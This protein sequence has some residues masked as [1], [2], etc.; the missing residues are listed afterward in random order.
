MTTTGVTLNG[1]SYTLDLSKY[2][3]GLESALRQSFNSS[4]EPGDGA[5]ASNAV[6][7]RSQ[8]DFS[9]GSG[10]R[11]FDPTP[12]SNRSSFHESTGIDPWRKGYLSLLPAV[13]SHSTNLASNGELIQAGRYVVYAS[14]TSGTINVYDPSNG[15]TTG[16]A[17]G[18]GAIS[19]LAADGEVVYVA[20]ASKLR[21]FT[22]ATTTAADFVNSAHD[23][24]AVCHGRVIAGNG[25]ALYEYSAAGATLTTFTAAT[26]PTTAGWSWRSAAA[27]PG[28]ILVAGGGGSTTTGD[29]YG[30][31]YR[32][33]FDASTGALKTPVYPAAA[34]S[35]LERPNRMLYYG[36]FLMLG[37]TL[38]LRVATI[39]TSGNVT[40]GPVVGSNDTGNRQPSNVYALAPSGKFVYFGWSNYNGTQTGLG[41]IDLS[42]FWRG[43][44]QPAYASDLLATDQGAVV[45]VAF[46]GGL[47][48]FSVAA[49]TSTVYKSSSNKVSAGL[50]YTGE[51]QYGFLGPK[52]AVDV[53]F[54]H[55]ALPTGASVAVNLFPVE[56]TSG[57][58]LGTSSTAASYGPTNPYD[59]QGLSSDAF[60]LE[61]ILYRA[62]ATTTGPQLRRWICRSAPIPRRYEIIVAPFI[63]RQIVDDTNGA[64]MMVDSWTEYQAILTAARSGLVTYT[65]GGHSDTVRIDTVEIDGPTHWSTDP[66]TGDKSFF[67]CVCVVTM[68]TMA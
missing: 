1:R 62:T 65:E 53:D 2:K 55:D 54:R 35:T 8:V 31:L 50:L 57:T 59:G 18:A 6:W 9:D 14:G 22:I 28:F 63:L 4:E 58:T 46:S 29:T 61:F 41:R 60:Y 36:G 56:A 34:L 39:D 23:F 16:Y 64:E 48:F 47:T 66:S 10:E 13:A 12:N 43:P 68:E 25:I 32:I 38:G 45:G 15:V 5:L 52:A 20:G 19:R 33:E 44:L 67:E 30:G 7:R 27:V 40:Y 11:F 49:A 26:I 3:R 21:T 42:N 24:V 51:L 17:T 37:T